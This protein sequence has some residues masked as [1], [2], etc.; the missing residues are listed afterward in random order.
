M[1]KCY[2][3]PFENTLLDMPLQE[4]WKTTLS[5]TV[6]TSISTAILLKTAEN[7]SWL[8]SMTQSHPPTGTTRADGIVNH[9]TL[10]KWRIPHSYTP[11]VGYSMC[12][13]T[14]GAAL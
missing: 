1:K 9:S 10:Y 11:K 14:S 8:I 2:I 3:F 7:S 5:Y 12:S 4:T 13:S 6:K